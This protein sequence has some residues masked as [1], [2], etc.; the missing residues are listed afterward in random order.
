M[1][2]DKCDKPTEK[3]ED[4]TIVEMS[5][6]SPDI[7]YDCD[8]FLKI[9]YQIYSFENAILWINKYSHKPL[10]TKLRILD[11]SW[12]SFI[13]KETDI[14]PLMEN[15]IDIYLNIIKQS[16]IKKIYIN[17]A[18]YIHIDQKTISIGE[19]DEKD[20]NNHVVEKI[21]YI[22]KKLL[23]RNDLYKILSTYVKQNIIKW[24]NIDNHNDE[25]LN[26]IITYLTNRIL[27][28]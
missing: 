11:C 8:K 9:Y 17:I 14:D 20:V 23:T 2:I 24:T 15:L 27:H 19:K 5:I 16:W 13:K 3:I 12:K 28:S 26:N 21:N 4:K 22:I 1:Y 6:I 10:Y 18:P 25:I 7:T